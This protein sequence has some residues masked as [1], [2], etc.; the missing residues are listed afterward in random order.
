MSETGCYHVESNHV[1][2]NQ[3]DRQA[4]RRSTGENSKLSTKLHTAHT[5]GQRQAVSKHIQL[6]RQRQTDREADIERRAEND[7]Q[8][9]R[10]TDI[11]RQVGG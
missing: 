7:R 8:S 6:A 1:T 2:T 5:G 10:Q 11:D 3:T 9:E 4:S